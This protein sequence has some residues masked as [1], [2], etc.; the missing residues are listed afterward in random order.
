MRLW[1]LH[2]R[3]LDRQGLL[4]LWREGLLAQ[5]VL[6]GKT[7]GYKHHPQLQRFRETADPMAAVGYYLSAVAAEAANR[8]YNFETSKILVLSAAPS[9][10]PVTRG[11]LKFE[12]LH[13]LRK[14]KLRDPARG[15]D[16]K[17]KKRIFTNP[18]FHP[19]AGKIHSWEKL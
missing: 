9:S 2:P 16:L 14:L 8:G 4:A 5:K 12:C 13:L 7:K 15:K 18:I 6:A 11:Q 3:Y 19:V 1:S 17:G 10:I